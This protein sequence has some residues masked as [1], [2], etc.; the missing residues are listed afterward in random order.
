[1]E[2]IIPLFFIAG[3]SA[4]FSPVLRLS[5]VILLQLN[6]VKNYID[7]TIKMLQGCLPQLV[8]TSRALLAPKAHPLSDPEPMV[9]VSCGE[10]RQMCNAPIIQ[11]FTSE[12]L[13]W[14]KCGRYIIFTCAINLFSSLPLVAKRHGYHYTTS[15]P[16]SSSTQVISSLLDCCRH[17]PT[18]HWMAN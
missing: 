6:W 4:G 18:P 9:C 16:S 12:E 11:R 3:S 10:R 2:Q 7:L 17:S 15:H 13:Q 8:E 14:R 5:C 1:M